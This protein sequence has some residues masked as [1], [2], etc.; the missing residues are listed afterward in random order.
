MIV[1]HAVHVFD[2]ESAR[3]Q[4]VESK[5][6]DQ[7]LL[8]SFRFLRRSTFVHFARGRLETRSHFFLQSIFKHV[9]LF[10][11]V[12]KDQGAPGPLAKNLFEF[13]PTFAV[14]DVDVF[15]GQT[16][17]HLLAELWCEQS[18]SPQTFRKRVFVLPWRTWPKRGPAEQTAGQAAK[19]FS[20]VPIKPG[21]TKTSASSI[22]RIFKTLSET[23]RRPIIVFE[24]ARCRDQYFEWA[25]NTFFSYG[26]V[27]APQDGAER[28][29]ACRASAF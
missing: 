20:A 13:G 3:G 18:R 15:G 21:S 1:D 14:H 26:K 17:G 24:S 19:I 27:S 23:C 29:C 10:T 7:T 25:T 5:D 12:A 11:R 4:V 22:T 16:K 8:K 28:A 6:F 2:I 9:A